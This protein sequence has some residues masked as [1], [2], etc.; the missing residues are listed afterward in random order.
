VDLIGVPGR[1]PELG[2]GK[3]PGREQ[4][5]RLGL[6]TLHDQPHVLIPVILGVL[7]WKSQFV[8]L[9]SCSAR[10][11]GRSHVSSLKTRSPIHGAIVD[12]IDP[13]HA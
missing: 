11:V 13:L 5:Q 7:F 4:D 12:D 1:T 10:I 2:H 6:K 8:P 9:R 3:M